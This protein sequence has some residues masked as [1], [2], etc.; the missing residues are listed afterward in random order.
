MGLSHFYLWGMKMITYVNPFYKSIFIVTSILILVLSTGC[1]VDRGVIYDITTPSRPY[2]E[3]TDSTWGADAFPGYACV[4]DSIILRWN[5]DPSGECE[6]PDRCYYTYVTDNL[7]L[8]TR[9]LGTLGTGYFNASTLGVHVNGSISDLPEGSWSGDNPVFTFNVTNNQYL[10]VDPG[11]GTRESEVQIVQN[12]PA[13]P[14]V[15]SIDIPSVCSS[16]NQWDV[17]QFIVNTNNVSFINNAR[18]FGNCVRVV[19]VCYIPPTTEGAQYPAEIDLTIEPESETAINERL[20]RGGCIEGLNLNKRTTYF[21]Q[22][23]PSPALR[24]VGTC[25]STDTGTS[26]GPTATEPPFIQLQFTLGCEDNLDECDL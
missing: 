13:V 4:D 16:S 10:P 21:I 17:S 24:Y 15:P 14:I 20:P 5:T 3:A 26:G 25:S 18:G 2:S 6:D 23:V 19:S 7:G 1:S 12:P 9:D 22:A 11:F 8:L